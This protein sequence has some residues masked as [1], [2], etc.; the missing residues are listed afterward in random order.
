MP[1]NED[2]SSKASIYRYESSRD[3]NPTKVGKADRQIG[4]CVIY[5]D[6][7]QSLW[8]LDEANRKAKIEQFA[9]E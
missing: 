8:P 7:L 9:K 3:A 6:E 4:H 2:H 5:E 1:P